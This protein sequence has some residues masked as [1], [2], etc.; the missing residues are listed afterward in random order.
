MRDGRTAK[1]IVATCILDMDG[2]INVNAHGSA[3]NLDTNISPSGTAWQNGV[4]ATSNSTAVLAGL[5]NGGSALL[6][7][8]QGYGPADINLNSIFSNAEVT[9][10]LEGTSSGW[11][12]R[13][14]GTPGN[15]F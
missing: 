9:N 12:G 6:P 11:P 2:R 13:Y 5:A 1:V 3:L 7:V 10:I 15:Q 4:T 14:G 8:G